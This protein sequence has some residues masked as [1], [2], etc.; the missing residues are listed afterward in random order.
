MRA[1]YQK[2]TPAKLQGL[3]L[4]SRGMTTFHDRKEE[5]LSLY[6]TAGGSRSFFIRR[7][8]AGKEI[9]FILGHFPEMSIE[10]ARRATREIKCQLDRGEDPREEAKRQK[11]DKS[12]KEAFELFVERYGRREKKTWL[13]DVYNV[14]RFL[15]HW[16]QRPLAS[17][18]KLEL[19][20]LHE[21]I[22]T[23]HGPYQAN[24]LLDCV[25]AIYNKMREWG[26]EGQNPVIGIRRFKEI[27]R[28]R[29]LRRG[30]WQAFYKALEAE[31]HEGWRDFFLLCLWTG[32]RKTNILCMRWEE[33][34]GTAQ[35][36][37]IPDSKNGEPVCVPLV[38]EALALLEK[39]K[40]SRSSSWVFPSTRNASGHF[41]Q[42]KGA[43][44]RLLKR[45]GIH[46]LRIHDLRRTM[47]SY[48]AING[49]SLPIIGK[50]LG[51]KSVLSTHIY[52]RLSNDP[53]R[54]SMQQ[55]VASMRN[56]LEPLCD[57]L[58]T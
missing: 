14:N 7:R 8:V 41:T 22:G 56:S 35:E 2:F 57:A 40:D 27:K 21:Q 19:Q 5:G 17:I 53:V 10:E 29:F 51:H 11:M 6:L 16:F 37:R 44:E 54:Q 55:A 47:G 34:D 1:C 32:A 30:E 24:R 15:S 28:D 39:R 20:I 43:W 3:A 50:S 12:F 48:Q 31:P 46:D 58:K 25:R 33:I 13:R 18:T 26:W 42:P 45:A 52:A 23:H 49:S 38:S 36:W 4:P 9:R